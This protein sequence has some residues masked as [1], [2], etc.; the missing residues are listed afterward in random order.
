MPISD[1]Y[2]IKYVILKTLFDNKEQGRK[3]PREMIGSERFK[4][5][6]SYWLDVLSDLSDDTLIK[7]LKIRQCKD[8]RVLCGLDNIEITGTGIDYLHDNSKMKQV[9]DLFKDLKDIFPL[10]LR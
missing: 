3:T 1:Y 8:T 2:K 9:Y 7:G 5:P 6:E 4:I 10:I